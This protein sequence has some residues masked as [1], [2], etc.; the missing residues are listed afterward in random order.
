MERIRLANNKDL[1]IFSKEDLKQD[2]IDNGYSL[3]YNLKAP[4]GEFIEDIFNR[5]FIILYVDESGTIILKDRTKKN[6]YETI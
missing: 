6:N 4:K 1:V 5:S 3:R 2:V